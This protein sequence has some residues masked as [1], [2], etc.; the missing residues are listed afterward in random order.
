[1][2][3]WDRRYALPLLG[4]GFLVLIA[5]ASFL[6]LDLTGPGPDSASSLPVVD[7]GQTGVGLDRAGGG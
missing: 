1:M 7:I 3:L 6:I 5:I 4:A 2:M